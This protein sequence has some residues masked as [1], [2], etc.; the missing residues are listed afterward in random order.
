MLKKNADVFNVFKQFKTMV[1]KKTRKSIKCLRT[2]NGSEFTSLE[3]E[4]FCK[5]EGIV[6]HKTVFYTPQQNGVAKRMNQTLMERSRSIINNANMP[7]ELWAEAISTDFHLV[8][9]SPSVAINCKI[10]EQVWSS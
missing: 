2:G 6:R 10:I 4:Q 9:I 1:E 5:D 3:F 8:N 7:K